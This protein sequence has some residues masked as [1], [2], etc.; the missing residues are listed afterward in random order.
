MEPRDAARRWR[1]IW[2]HAWPA[3]DVGAI[4]SL[5]GDDAVFRSHPFREAHRGASGAAAYAAWAFADEE[6]PTECRFGEPFVAG[7]HAT[8]EYWA[9]V[10]SGGSEQTIAG[11]SVL[12]F[13]ADGLVQAQRDYWA[14]ADG[15]HEPPEG[16]GK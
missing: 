2:L 11:V 8:C 12:R 16:W 13:G 4:R 3:R 15:R 6:A 7:D 1:E 5:Y 9:V 14:I 10:R